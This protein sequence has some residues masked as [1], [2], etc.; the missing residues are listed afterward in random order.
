MV[1]LIVHKFGGSCLKDATS[2]AKTLNILE[3]F[4]GNKMIFVCSALSNITDFL[5]ETATGVADHHFDIEERIEH[6]K[7]RHLILIN[8]VIMDENLR[9]DAINFIETSLKRLKNTLYGVWEIGLATRSID[10]ILSFGERLSTYIYYTYLRERGEKVEYFS[11]ETLIYTNGMFNN[12]LPLFNLTEKTIQ[13]KIEPVLQKDTFPVV[14]GYI[15]ANQEGHITTLGR[16]GS[17]LTATLMAYSLHIPHR[18]TYV[19]LWKDV[20]GLLTA[21]PKLEPKARLIPNISYAEAREL[22]FFGSKVLHPLCIFPMEKRQIPIQIRNFDQPGQEN[23]TTIEATQET[24]TGIVKAITV[25]DAAMITVES[26][27]MVSLPGTAAK[28]FDILGNAGVNVIMIS[29][30]SSENNITFLVE[31]KSGEAAKKALSQSKFF[32][33]QWFNIKLDPNISLIAIV[34]AGMAY[35]PGV[36]GRIFTALGSAKANVRAIA[37]GSSEINISIAV[38]S[39]DATHAV[40]AIHKEFSLGD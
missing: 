14:T 7:E 17:D 27:A 3:K 32:G 18:N 33:Q 40:Q 38:E 20:D 16:G 39:K 34:G 6:V 37:Q 2:F 5:L 8:Q 15:S 11:G 12:A 9:Q 28:V 30:G 1:D 23:F 19:V 24:I 31:R 21:N 13:D 4:R 25:Q 22:A 10:F 36:A 26:D 35:T 29:Q